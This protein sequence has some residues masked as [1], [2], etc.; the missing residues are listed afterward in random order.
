MNKL[1]FN[2][3]KSRSNSIHISI[4]QHTKMVNYH[5]YFLPTIFY[6]DSSPFVHYPCIG[7]HFDDIGCVHSVVQYYSCFHV[8]ATPQESE[9]DMPTCRCELGSK[10]YPMFGILECE[11]S[12]GEESSS[13]PSKSLQISPP[14]F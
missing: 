5:G 11:E 7:D 4:L 13:N 2:I 10:P 3:N 6:M 14:L 9:L 8:S 1:E 12:R